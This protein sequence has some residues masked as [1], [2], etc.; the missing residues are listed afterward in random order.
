[1]RRCTGRRH[2]GVI[3]WSW[4]DR[5]SGR[6]NGREQTNADGQYQESKQKQC[7]L[8]H[9]AFLA[10]V[11]G[12]GEG[13]S[14]ACS[15]RSTVATIVGLLLISIQRQVW[16]K[17]TDQMVSGHAPH[18]VKHRRRNLQAGCAR[19]KKSPVRAIFHGQR[20]QAALARAVSWQIL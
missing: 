2:W 12:T 18:R 3:R 15:V 10:R 1:M 20:F 16:N 9:G 4:P 7:E 11:A 19:Q 13:S 17:K 8:I 5:R 6:R 14:C